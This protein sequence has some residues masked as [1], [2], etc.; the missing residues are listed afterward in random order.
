MRHAALLIVAC[1]LAV[2]AARWLT[3]REAGGG[4]VDVI[5]PT[6]RIHVTGPHNTLAS[7]AAQVNDPKLLAYDEAARSAVCRATLIV[8]GELDLGRPGD[9]ESGETLEL[10]TAVCGDLRIVVPEGGRLSLHHSAI[11]TN[12]IF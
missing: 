11:R 5:F 3:D 7:L 1:A 10:A 12:S 4:P 2:V 6:R 8:E 9:P